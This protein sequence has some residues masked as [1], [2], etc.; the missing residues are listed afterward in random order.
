MWVANA[1]SPGRPVSANFWDRWVSYASP[2]DVHGYDYMTSSFDRFH[3]ATPS[4]PSLSSETS[5]T[6]SDRGEVANNATA[7]HIAGYDVAVPAWG[8]T[9]EGAWGGVNITDGQGILTRDFIAGCVHAGGRKLRCRAR[10]GRGL[11]LCG[12]VD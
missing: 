11:A 2:P 9:A 6:Q 8:D 7:G 5:S 1:S 10:E 4:I 12:G 3:A